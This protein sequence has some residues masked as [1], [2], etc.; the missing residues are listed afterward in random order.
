MRQYYRGG[1]YRAGKAPTACFIA[2]CFNQIKLV[3]G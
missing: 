3:S 1:K 2:S